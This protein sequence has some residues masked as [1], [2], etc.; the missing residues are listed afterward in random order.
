MERLRYMERPWLTLGEPT[1]TMRP[2][3]AWPVRSIA[4][5][6]RGQ[7]GAPS[8][9]LAAWHS[10]PLADGRAR[11]ASRAPQEDA[12]G[13]RSWWVRWLVLACVVGGRGAV[14][15]GADELVIGGQCDRTG[16]T[17]AV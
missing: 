10:L 6:R 2:R 9:A 17:K 14:P 11:A 16:P 4:C 3:R 13:L 15:A 12:M 5:T 1:F 8:R 7:G